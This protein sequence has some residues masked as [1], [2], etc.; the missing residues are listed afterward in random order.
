MQKKSPTTLKAK[1]P[2][3][4]FCRERERE[5]EK[6]R[7]RS[8]AILCVMRKGGAYEAY[9]HHTLGATHCM[10]I[11]A[12]GVVVVAAVWEVVFLQPCPITALHGH[13]SNMHSYDRGR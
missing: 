10:R 11:I 2:L 9:W 4:C 3:I 13:C 1:T 6:G 12:D 5:G 7:E 8:A